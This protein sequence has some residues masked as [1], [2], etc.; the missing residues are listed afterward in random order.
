ME[1]S[2]TSEN[3]RDQRND[4]KGNRVAREVIT[5]FGF[6]TY[7]YVAGRGGSIRTH[8]AALISEGV[9]IDKTVGFDGFDV[10][11]VDQETANVHKEMDKTLPAL[12]YKSYPVKSTRNVYLDW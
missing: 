11:G 3:S 12:T 4:E 2:Q 8:L 6:V 7:S 10:F 5:I 9:E 1:N